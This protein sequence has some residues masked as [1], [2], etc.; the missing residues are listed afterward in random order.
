MGREGGKKLERL[1]GKFFQSLP[2]EYI[3]SLE[4][5]DYVVVPEK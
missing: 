4:A 1:D 2:Q 3:I 5:R